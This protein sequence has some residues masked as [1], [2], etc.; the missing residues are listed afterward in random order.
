MSTTFKTDRLENQ[1]VEM[2]DV[3]EQ[4]E[5]ILNTKA[6]ER[7]PEVK[8]KRSVKHLDD[9]D[10]EKPLLQL[11]P[12]STGRQ[13]LE[14]QENFELLRL[15]YRSG[16]R[17]SVPGT[18][19]HEPAVLPLNIVLE[20]ASAAT[21]EIPAKEHGSLTGMLQLVAG[22]VWQHNTF[23]FAQ[24]LHA[25]IDRL[26][27]KLTASGD[28]RSQVD[29]QEPLQI[30]LGDSSAQELDG[31]AFSKLLSESGLTNAISPRRKARIEQTLQG[32]KALVHLFPL[33]PEN[34]AD[35]D[36]QPAAPHPFI[37][38]IATSVGELQEL[39][40]KFRKEFLLFFK[41][42]KVAR[43]EVMNQY[44]EEIHDPLFAQFHPGFLSAAERKVLPPIIAHLKASTLTPADYA[45]L[46][47]LLSVKV[48]V[49]V[50]LE[51]ETACQ[52]TPDSDVTRRCLNHWAVGL[53]KIVASL[54]N[55]FVLQANA[56][57]EKLL[58][59]G[60]V[61]GFRRF[62]AALFAVYR[63]DTHNLQDLNDAEVASAAKTARVF[64][65]FLFTPLYK[66]DLID[67]F[68]IYDNHAHD[69]AWSEQSFSYL[70]NRS[71]ERRVSQAF[72][73]ADFLLLDQA[74]RR[75]FLI[76]PPE[77]WHDDML[78]L[79]EFIE[80]NEPHRSDKLPFFWAADADNVMWRVLPSRRIVR[81]VE[82]VAFNWRLLQEA[83]GVRSARMVQMLEEKRQRLQT[84]KTAEAPSPA[85]S[86]T[87][88]PVID[89]K[90]IRVD[91]I[92]KILTGLLGK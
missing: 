17:L 75:E 28:H 62:D 83:G 82:L 24:E 27:Q 67:R 30:A 23:E 32:L 9:V 68:D 89:E 91:T 51:V 12:P 13:R 38:N 35:D 86:G 15:F 22:R 20:R 52:H 87:K 19:F 2:L 55:T 80:L 3:L 25:L 64:P 88:Q 78:P 7:P 29:L 33:E 40:R 56:Q 74:Y 49:K 71:S 54:G 69:Q 63:P 42:V 61:D 8:P 57:E 4:L 84:G 90:Q 76:I 58:L 44:H 6:G 11:C 10:I 31:A 79:T 50:L 37:T 14:P 1:N 73:A 5:E 60:F 65:S 70:G 16:V 53:G 41:A 77:R 66:N 72:T 18:A 39:Q 48:P 21:G 59:R 45:L 81:T 43:L 46:V 36:Y 26:T 34:T 47:E 92:S 85:V